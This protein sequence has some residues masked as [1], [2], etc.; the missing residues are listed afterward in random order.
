MSVTE[1]ELL[2]NGEPIFLKGFGKHEDFPIFGKG[3]AHPVM[4]KDY[5]LMKWTGANSF[6]TSHYPYDEEYMRMADREGFLIIDETPAVGLYFHGDTAELAQRQEMNK[7]YINELISRD[8][9]HPSVIMWCIANEPFPESLTPGAG[10]R[11]ATPESIASFEELFA[12]VK[13]LDTT[14]LATL[15]GVMGGPAEWVGLADI[16]CINRYYGWY[17]HLG[18]LEGAA[19]LLGMELDGLHKRFNKPIIIT[20]FGADTYPG[21]RAVEPEMFTEEFQTEF[22]KTYLDVA[23][24]RDYMA[25]MHVWAF[26][27]FRTSQGLIR[28]GGI[29]HKGVFTRDRNPKA[30]AHYLRSRW[31]KQ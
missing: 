31:T 28:F 3:T 22:I 6:R 25:G 9:N 14:R 1:N 12:L 5:A 11:E 24:A 4:V 30:A 19:T 27:D 8:K 23:A 17:T 7:Q 20:E 2:L 26:A 16:I 10:S 18:D 29:N 13:Q 15:V 21:M